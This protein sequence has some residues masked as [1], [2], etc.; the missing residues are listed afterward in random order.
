LRVIT[1]PHDN[2]V[3]GMVFGCS[4]K[5]ACKSSSGQSAPHRVDSGG[6]TATNATSISATDKHTQAH[7][8]RA[9][10][11]QNVKGIEKGMLWSP[12][13]DP[14][15][16]VTTGTPSPSVAVQLSTCTPVKPSQTRQCGSARPKEDR[17]SSERT[18]ERASQ[19]ED[20]RKRC[21]TLPNTKHT[22]DTAGTS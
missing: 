21:I 22:K 4:V 6:S 8:S 17:E 5:T 18:S 2:T 16:I 13:C 15:V 12:T 7:S 9:R 19:S 1:P 10:S 3:S 20:L 11:R 14:G